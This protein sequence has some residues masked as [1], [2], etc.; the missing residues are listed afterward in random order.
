VDKSTL[1][2]H[3]PLYYKKSDVIDNIN[4]ANAAELTNFTD[5]LTN[6][7]DQ[8]FIDTADTSL[9]RWE[10]DLGIPIDNTKD[11]DFRRSVI[12]SRLR[13]TGTVTIKL[14]KNVSESF[15]N[16][17]VDV[18]EHNESYTFT[19]KF[20]GTV[21]IPPNMDDL[22]NA[23]EEIKPAH[24]G[25]AFEYVYNTHQVLSAFTHA[26]LSVYT[27]DQLRNEVIT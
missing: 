4:A 26:D 21:G 6:L 22:A 10:K 27:H 25:Y 24:L 14:I 9:E 23:I 8:F 5:E 15:S 3:M 16:G 18:V 12:K 13:G 19:V 17:V 11:P 2:A 7:L 20:V 1:L